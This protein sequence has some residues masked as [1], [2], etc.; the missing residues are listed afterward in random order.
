VMVGAPLVVWLYDRAFLA[1]S[2]AAALRSRRALYAG[3]AA[4]WLLLLLSVDPNA[5]SGGAAWAGFGLPE[6]SAAEYARSQSG[7]ILHYLR[8]CFWPH[9]LVLDYGWPVANDLGPILWST[10]LVSVLGLATLWALWR[11]PPIGFLGAFFFLVLAPTSSVLPIIDLAYEHRM[12]L[13]LVAV[14]AVGVVA[15][16]A[17]FARASAPAWARV[18]LLVTVVAS[19]S[20]T[21]VLR[22][23]D[24]RSV[25]AL[26]RTVVDAVPGNYRGQANLGAALSK[27]NRNEEALVFLRAAIALNPDHLTAHSNLGAALLALGQIDEAEVHMLRVLKNNPNN[28]V[29]TH[30]YGKLR[31]QRA[32]LEPSVERLRAAVQNDPRDA[33]AHLN[34][35]STLLNMGQR[36]EALGYFLEAIRLDPNLPEAFS[37]V[38][39]ILATHPDPSVRDYA[40]AVRLAERAVEL[41]RGEVPVILSVLATAYE[42]AGQRDR[43]TRTAE[44]ALQRATGLGE[45]R[46]AQQIRD[47]L[48]RYRRDASRAEPR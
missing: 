13:P 37:G 19:L 27:L 25:E 42:A 6:I 24:Y 45:T 5:L 31:E 36:D 15:V 3:L 2:F 18:A 47:Q 44:Q 32:E 14:V 43:A 4:T 12:Y 48:K 10:A 38:A 34:L 30:N 7:V 16:D 9:P 35:A 22:N 29:V 39:W 41:S 17:A 46:E 33:F 11:V 1:G 23:R 21:T 8:L 40:E 28:A 26:W 20:A